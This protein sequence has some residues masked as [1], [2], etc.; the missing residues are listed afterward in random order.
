MVECGGDWL[1]Y[2]LA[3]ILP[4]VYSEALA[5]HG[6]RRHGGGLGNAGNR[7][8]SEER[9]LC[10][11]II[12]SRAGWTKR[13]WQFDPGQRFRGHRLGVSWGARGARGDMA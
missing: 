12:S 11:K 3:R 5:E 9:E 4:F 2:L 13:L 8:A 7:W 10:L 6:S 1:I